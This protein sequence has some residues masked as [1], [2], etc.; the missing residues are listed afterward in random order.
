MHIRVDACDSEGAVRR[1]K[2]N[3]AIGVVA[4]KTVVQGVTTIWSNAKGIREQVCPTSFTTPGCQ[5]CKK[6]KN[7]LT[8][9]ERKKTQNPGFTLTDC[10]KDL[11][12]DSN[13]GLENAEVDIL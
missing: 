1:L 5:F 13:L 4:V 8:F 10:L 6:K 11:G 9:R 2:A 3:L 7:P 12:H